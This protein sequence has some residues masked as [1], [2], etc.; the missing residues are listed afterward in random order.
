MLLEQRNRP[1]NYQMCGRRIFAVLQTTSNQAPS[2]SRLLPPQSHPQHQETLRWRSGHR[3]GAAG[4]S[5]SRAHYSGDSRHNT[6]R[7]TPPAAAVIMS[8]GAAAPSTTARYPGGRVSF[9]QRPWLCELQPRCYLAFL[10]SAGE[11][12]LFLQSAGGATRTDLAGLP[13]SRCA[14][15]RREARV[16]A[17]ERPECGGEHRDRRRDVAGRRGCRRRRAVRARVG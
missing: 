9:E 11:A 7:T 15:G 5:R 17:I 4:A 14:S 10:Q 1:P 3:H 12:A 6:A 13:T 16:L 8:S 2:E